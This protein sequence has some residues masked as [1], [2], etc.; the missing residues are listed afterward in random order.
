MP[1]RIKPL[2]EVKVRTAKPMGKEYKIFD[3][4]GLYLQITTTGGKL[5]RF[6]YRI[7]KKDDAKHKTLAFGSYPD[8]SLQNARKKT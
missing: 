3:G 5:W 1:K 4:D 6:K 7:G 2:S 8:V